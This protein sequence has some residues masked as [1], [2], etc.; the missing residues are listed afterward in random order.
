MVD[1]STG[2]ARTLPIRDAEARDLIAQ[3]QALQGIL[4]RGTALALVDSVD[5]D[6][7][8]PSNEVIQDAIAHS[9][10]SL[11][12]GMTITSR[13]Y[14]SS[15]Q[16][17][18]VAGKPNDYKVYN[19]PWSAPSHDSGDGTVD[20]LNDGF[21]RTG[22]LFLSTKTV[23]GVNRQLEYV[24]RVDNNN[25]G[26]YTVTFDEFGSTGSLKGLAFKD[27]ATVTGTA[28]SH[29]HSYQKAKIGTALA[30]QQGTVTSSGSFTPVGTNASS[31]VTG[32]AT[33]KPKGTNASSAVTLTGGGTSKLVTTSITG[34]NGTESV[35]KVTKTASKLVTTTITGTN[36]TESV[37]KVTK[38]ASKLVTS[39]VKQVSA[40]DRSQLCKVSVD[41]DTLVLTP[42]SFD[43]VTVATGAVA[44]NG[45]GSDIVT[46]VTITDKTVAK[47][48]SAVTVATGAV[49]SDGSGSAIVTGVTITDKTVAKAGSAV[50]VATGN[51]DSTGSG[52][53]V[54]VSLPTGGTAAAQ[55]F[56]GTEE[57]VDVSGTA[58]AQK[59]TGTAGNVS[60]SGTSNTTI[61]TALALAYDSVESGGKSASVSGTAS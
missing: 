18:L 36:G 29:T 53:T 33:I 9:G 19:I 3:L 56:T 1:P 48:G 32:S 60:V 38:T 8:A 31:S 30:L 26:T 45:G 21:L 51:V 54:A 58:A 61:K 2:Q 15:S 57:S 11:E 17:L 6:G 14:G 40:A 42:V 34:T 47:T 46:G 55:T 7:R 50:T 59:F 12:D 27:S 13:A 44:S 5:A 35:S 37:S 39:T 20:G 4:Y 52:A 43:D 49:A 28:A 41:G 23:G 22:M 16:T 24:I 25:N 10:F